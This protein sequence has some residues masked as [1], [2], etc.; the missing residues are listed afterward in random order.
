MSKV[1]RLVS[2]SL[3]AR[4]ERRALLARLRPRRR[5]NV[6][7]ETSRAAHAGFTPTCLASSSRLQE[8]SRRRGS[9]P[10]SHAGEPLFP[11]S[12]IRCAFLSH[13][14]A[15]FAAPRG[16][17]ERNP[18]SHDKGPADFAPACPRSL[19]RAFRP[20]R[21][22]RVYPPCATRG[23]QSGASEYRP[24]PQES[25]PTLAR[26]SVQPVVALLRRSAACITD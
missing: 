17:A 25:D 22:C 6:Y 12:M 7:R 11:T 5:Y 15:V 16:G 2:V 20:C 18:P 23:S 1:P 8:F 10:S 24:S 21:L 14:R 3:N 9:I 26:G 19:D 13:S 4:A